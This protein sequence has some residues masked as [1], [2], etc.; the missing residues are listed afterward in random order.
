MVDFY[1]SAGTN[2]DAR[3]FDD[4][5]PHLDAVTLKASVPT[6]RLQSWHM[7]RS[8]VEVRVFFLHFLA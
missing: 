8:F 4:Y 6:S 7:K 5:D 3:C 1:A 2:I